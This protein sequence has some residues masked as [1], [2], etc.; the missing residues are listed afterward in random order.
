MIPEE[1]TIAITIIGIKINIISPLSCS[2]IIPQKLLKNNLINKKMIY[3]AY[4]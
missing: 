1:V 4:E 3:L 2:S